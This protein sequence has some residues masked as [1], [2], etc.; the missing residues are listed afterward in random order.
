MLHLQDTIVASATPPGE[1]ALAIVRLSGNNALEIAQ[2]ISPTKKL[3]NSHQLTRAQLFHGAE[4][5]L[6]DDAMLVELHAP[7]SATGENMVEFYVHGSRAI[8]QSLISECIRLGARHAEAGEYSL[9]SFINGKI[10]LTQA[11]AIA[12]I[13]TAESDRELQVAQAQ[14]RGSLSKQVHHLLDKIETLISKWRAALDFPDY[15]TGVGFENDDLKVLEQIDVD[16]KKLIKS[17]I[18]SSRKG[19]VIVLGGAPNAGKSTL[20]NTWLGTKRVLVDDEPGTTRDPIEVPL[21]DG[22]MRFSLWDTA[23]IREHATPLEEQ[24]IALSHEKMHEADLTLWLMSAIDPQFPQNIAT[25]LLIVGSKADLANDHRRQQLEQQARTS[26]FTIEMWVSAQTGE[27][28]E[29]LKDLVKFRF[30][31]ASRD[32]NVFTTKARHI[33]ALQS[34]KECLALVLQG[35][36][37]KRPLDLLAMDLEKVTRPL[38]GILGR[39]IDEE[40]LSNIFLQFCIGK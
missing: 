18:Y 7:R 8:V 14:L 24:G 15:D 13:I 22:L 5:M 28:I 31:P 1:S 39:D 16:I 33:E 40:I 4:K 32:S 3:R 25:N 38:G 6:L 2:T 20:L 23:G 10:D 17:N 35:A 11:E 21:T 19:R 36:V 26:G 29:Q 34:S 27:G 37:M 30:E 9:R 12:D